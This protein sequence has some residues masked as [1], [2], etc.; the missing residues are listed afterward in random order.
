MRPSNLAYLSVVCLIS[1]FLIIS[2]FF[3]CLTNK[4][5]SEL[6]ESSNSFSQDQNIKAKALENYAKIPLSFEA[7]QGQADDK[8]KF[9]SR[10]KGYSFLLTE[11]ETLL[12]L[13]NDSQEKTSLVKMKFLGS[14]PKP[15]IEPID[16][17]FGKTNYFIGNN[18]SNWHTDLPIYN[19]VKYSEVY[20]GID[21]IYYGNQQQIE[22]DLL[23]KP[24]AD[25]S[26]ISIQI[27]TNN[28][29]A[30]E[31]DLEGNLVIET[32]QG[33]LLKHKPIIYQEIEGEKQIIAG[34][35][36]L[37]GD[38]LLGF[39]LGE[40]DITKPLVIDPIF[41]Y[42]TYFG[43]TD[44]D[45]GYGIN[46]DKLGNI[47]IT[48][49]T[50]STVF[51][52]KNPI[53]TK[54]ND[55][56]LEIFVTKLNPTATEIIY[57]TYLIGNDI[58]RGF[59]LLIDAQGNTYLTGETYSSDFP[60]VTPFQ[61]KG[62]G[63]AN[64]DAFLVKISPEGNKLLYSTY[65]GGSQ[66]ERAFN[67]ALTA[68]GN[69]VLAGETNSPDLP[70]KNAFQ[71]KKGDNFS[72][73]A[74]VV[75]FSPDG[76]S[77]DFAT[78][79]GGNDLDKGHGMTIDSDGNIYL[80]GE[81]N[82][83]NLPVKN[84]M[85]PSGGGTTNIDIFI[86]K[87]T[88]LGV[89]TFAT[90]FGTLDLDRAFAITVDSAKNIY[91]T[92]MTNAIDFPTVKPPQ[93]G[94]AGQLDAYVL[95]LD[96]TAKTVLFSTFL[97]GSRD[98]VGL[99]IAVD[100]SNN[101][102]VYGQTGSLQDFPTLRP[103]QA[104]STGG[105]F[106]TFLTKYNGNGEVVFSTY[107]GGSNVDSPG[108]MA[109]DL[110]GNVYLIGDTP[111]LDFPTANAFNPNKVGSDDI[112]II[113]I[114]DPVINCPKVSFSP[115]NLQEAFINTFYN[116]TI[117]IAASTIPYTFNL[118][119]K[120]PS[121][122][123]FNSNGLLFGTP[124]E[125]GSFNLLITATDP[126]G[127]VNTQQFTLV[128]REVAGDFNLNISPSLQSISAGTSTSFNIDLQG[129][130]NFSQAVTISA[131]INAPG[132][133]ISINPVSV[134]ITP[135][136]RTT[137]TVSTTN[138]TPLARYP[139]TFTGTVGNLAR[140]QMAIL[141]VTTNA[142]D[143]TISLSPNSTSLM[144]G[145]STDF[146]A[147]I[148]PI[149]GFS[150]PVSLQAMFSPATSDLT[151]SPQTTTIMPNNSATFTVKASSIA[152]GTFTVMLTAT[153]GQITRTATATVNVLLPDF[154]ITFNP[155]QVNITRGQSGQFTANISRSGGFT[156]NVTVNP[157]PTQ[158]KAL[159]IKV[160][161]TSQT[162]NAATTTFNFKVKTKAPLGRQQLS[163]TGRDEQGNIRSGTL[164]LI[165]Q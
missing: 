98:E 97:G 38:N 18:P 86:A 144:A 140:S 163:F 137:F 84:A 124:T 28:S 146:I 11:Q 113:K 116:Q 149:R 120:L 52:L 150:A 96:P 156:G 143:F 155:A 158:L 26:Q 8:V 125:S 67:I 6:V 49:E 127:C 104:T 61:A 73:D 107:I 133:N 7:N 50:V 88:P 92:G 115:N 117:S 122:L 63:G 4:P 102:Y 43:T 130:S 109:L 75:R 145:A 60:T 162:T 25:P 54:E 85:Q 108:K 45:K 9:F 80:A 58:D 121:G 141:E 148:Q 29:S 65:F 33:K 68:G 23:V 103:L 77:I 142:P 119:G 56:S 110:E 24:G 87:F 32:S 78:Y 42:S 83:T 153:S 35:Y 126:N 12:T 135:G 3:Y 39:E 93:P 40:Y 21:A 57:S 118:T 151:L 64:I 165:I 157:D 132:A 13:K 47:Y 27:D 59:A 71:P 72:F 114:S 41:V 131:S 62:G 100:T 159:K 147:R 70:V 105:F 81:T 55:S 136:N 46:V 37:N 99:N 123:M 112:F 74:Y 164:T 19:K 139:I 128:V 111:S 48:G 15:R 66:V 53:Q 34:N 2:T 154:Q 14:N 22:Y 10:G 161:P 89:L 16:K 5:N 134:T 51:P 17:R 94:K 129:A 101:I 90:Y 20:P 76:S 36:K 44:N 30:L 1:L 91:L 79:F 69:I 106:D 95:K 82:S 31:I 152:S 160:N 138:S